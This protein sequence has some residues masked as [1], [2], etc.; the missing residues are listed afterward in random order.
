MTTQIT[1]A[2]II[3]R[4]LS[5]LGYE[6]VES[7]QGFVWWC[8]MPGV[9]AGGKDFEKSTKVYATKTQA[10]DAAWVY[11]QEIFPSAGKAAL[12]GHTYA[13]KGYCNEYLKTLIASNSYAGRTVAHKLKVA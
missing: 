4:F 2:R 3:K 7:G 6:I 13:I 9:I 12:I 5:L 11:F 1:N 10:W 8:A